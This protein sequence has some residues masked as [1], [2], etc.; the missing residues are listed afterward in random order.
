IARRS[1]RIVSPRWVGAVLPVRSLAQR[2]AELQVRRGLRKTLEIA[3]R[4]RPSLTTPQPG[5]PSEVAAERD[6]SRLVIRRRRAP[7]VQIR[8]PRRGIVSGDA[9]RE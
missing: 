8:A 7:D 9:G 2:L 4:E 6:T 5:E 1:R 3:R